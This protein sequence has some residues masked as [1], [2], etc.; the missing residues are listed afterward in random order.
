MQMEKRDFAE[1]KLFKLVAKEV[2]TAV[3]YAMRINKPRGYSDSVEHTGAD[4]EPIKFVE[5]KT[6]EKEE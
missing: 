5:I 6:Y 3:F 4:R 2:P 1:T